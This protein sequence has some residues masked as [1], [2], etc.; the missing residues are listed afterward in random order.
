MRDFSILKDNNLTHSKNGSVLKILKDV[1]E[2][3]NDFI[4][5]FSWWR[6]APKC[7]LCEAVGRQLNTQLCPSQHS[8][9]SH[10]LL[11]DMIMITILVHTYLNMYY[12]LCSNNN[13]LFNA[14][15]CTFISIHVDL[16]Q[17][18][19]SI[20]LLSSVTKIYSMIGSP[21]KFYINVVNW[22]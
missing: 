5:V 17:V 19:T 16:I 11:L 20:H 3:L 10:T 15:Y 4:M 8:S 1:L 6:C 22:F 21:I 2:I 9:L 14:R 7:T 18:E 12:I 13:S